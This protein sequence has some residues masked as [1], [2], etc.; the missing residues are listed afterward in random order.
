[1]PKINIFRIVAADE[2]IQKPVTVVIQPNGCV[3]VDPGRQSS[4]LSYAGKAV[5]L[6]IVKQ[7]GTSPLDEEQILISIII[8]ISPHRA[9]RNSGARLV[10]LGNAH[11]CG[12]VL[13]G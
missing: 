1:M 10:D 5:A 3:C 8:E 2:K 11:F 9:R 7:F 12:D 13:E 4:L 6:I